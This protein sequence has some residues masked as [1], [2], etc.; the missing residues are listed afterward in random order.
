VLKR[1]AV[2]CNVRL[3]LALWG[4]FYVA[5]CCSE[6]SVLF[7]E[8]PCVEHFVVSLQRVAVHCSVLPELE[9]RYM[10][11]FMCC[12][13]LQRVAVSFCS[14]LQ[15]VARAQRALHE[16]LYACSM[17]QQCV[18]S[19]CCSSVL[20]ELEEGC[21][22][23]MPYLMCVADLPFKILRMCQR[24]PPSTAWNSEFSKIWW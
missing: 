9:E 1:V 12:S 5:V 23:A 15:R 19:V 13:V 20:P 3:E 17:L 24:I 16:I 2:C 4:A 10:R 21:M 11:S 22:S 18:A 7:R 14:V 8:Y 6:S